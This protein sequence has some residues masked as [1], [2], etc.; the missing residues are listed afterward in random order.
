VVNDPNR[1]YLGV[2]WSFP[3]RPAGGRLTWTRYEDDVEQAI[4]IILET[5][6]Q[7]RVMRPAFGAGLRTHVFDTNGPVVHRG[8]EHEVKRA[9]VEQE[10]RILVEGVRA[11]ADPDQ[12]NVL[13]IEIDYVVKRSNS[14][15]NMVYPFYLTEGA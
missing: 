14:F 13:R 8:V 10:P 9:L 15:F 6:R 2:G 3:V 5:T 12:D 7:E 4:G 11:Y 1:E